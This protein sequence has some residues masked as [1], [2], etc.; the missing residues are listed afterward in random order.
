[1]TT[2]LSELIQHGGTAATITAAYQ[3]GLF[4]SLSRPTASEE[5]AKR[6]HLDPRAVSLVLDTLVALGVAESSD[7][8][9]GA[10]AALAPESG[11]LVDDVLRTQA[12]WAHL[13]RFLRTGERYARMDGPTSERSDNYKTLAEPLGRLFEKAALEL[14]RKL[15]PPGKRV[16]DIGAGSGVWSLAM[17]A[18]SPSAQLV[19]LDLAAVLPALCDRAALAGLAARVETI[20]GDYHSTELPGA[21]FDRIILANVLHLEA[22]RNAASLIAR[23]AK[24]LK[25]GADLVVI[26]SIGGHE[27]SRALSHAIYALHLAMRTHHGYAHPLAQLDLWARDAG[28]SR[29]RSIKLKAPPRNLT[30]LLYRS[31][32]SD[33][34]GGEMAAMA[35]ESIVDPGVNTPENAVPAIDLLDLH[36][37]DSETRSGTTERTLG[38]RLGRVVAAVWR[39]WAEAALMSDPLAWAYF[40]AAQDSAA[41]D[42]GP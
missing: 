42:G 33:R 12:L 40:V 10:C 18:R 8:R 34:G 19:A 35:M 41:P 28:L 13:P 37:G 39:S 29:R 7:G 27:P 21:S 1:M 16:L 38:Q 31:E 3:A 23:A 25:S 11:N 5:H 9:V 36:R 30:A 20:A 6:L 22:P 26:D 24:A 4:D 2:H 14:A 17:C 32:P 15:P